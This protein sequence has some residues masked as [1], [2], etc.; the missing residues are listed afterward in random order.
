MGDMNIDYTSN[1]PYANDQR[2]IVARCVCT[3]KIALPTRITGK[4]TRKLDI[5]ISNLSGTNITAGVFSCDSSDDL[6]ILCSI[7]TQKET[8][9]NDKWCYRKIDEETLCCFKN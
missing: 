8:L 9:K 1:C 3:N 7:S 5:C 4:T 6:V 2:D